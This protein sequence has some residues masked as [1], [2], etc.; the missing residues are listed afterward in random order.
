MEALQTESTGLLLLMVQ[1]YPLVS[2]ILFVMGALRTVIKPFMV[3][4]EKHVAE[5]PETTDDEKLAGIKSAKWYKALSFVLDY[6]ASVKL[7]K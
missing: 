4:Y 2:T 1:K 5:T 3:F 7:P 6:T